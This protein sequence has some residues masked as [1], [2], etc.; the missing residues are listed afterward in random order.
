VEHVA[1]LARIQLKPAE[2]K[3][4]TEQ[5]GDILNYFEK[6]KKLDTQDI[7]ITSQSIDLVDIHRPDEVKNY[8]Q[9]GQ[10][11]ILDNAPGRSGNY[12]KV[13]KIL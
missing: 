11:I 4:F 12:F 6:L 3:K 13:N 5:L 2:K 9:A 7:A 1:K 10:Q 8:N